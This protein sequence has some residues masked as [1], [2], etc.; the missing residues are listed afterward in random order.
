[1]KYVNDRSQT[2]LQSK[3]TD[4]PQAKCVYTGN[5]SNRLFVATRQ[6]GRQVSGS[7]VDF[8]KL[9]VIKLQTAAFFYRATLC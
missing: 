2:L 5:S 9:R 6:H 1:M 8:E 4:K 7:V 3:L